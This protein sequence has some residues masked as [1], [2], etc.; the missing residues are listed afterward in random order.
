MRPAGL[1]VAGLP[2][3]VFLKVGARCVSPPQSRCVK[4]CH[5]FD[6]LIGL[7]VLVFWVYCLGFN[8]AAG[9]RQSLL[10]KGAKHPNGFGGGMGEPTSHSEPLSGYGRF[11]GLA[12]ERPDRVPIGQGNGLESSC[13]GDYGQLVGQQNQ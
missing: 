10:G 11:D 9:S 5:Y 6:N 4:W 2:Q 8:L 13:A 7:F 3:L 1:D 12:V